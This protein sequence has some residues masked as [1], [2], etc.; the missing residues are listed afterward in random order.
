MIVRTARNIRIKL[1]LILE[2]PIARPTIQIPLSV[3]EA[4]PQKVLKQLVASV[5]QKE[6]LAD[7]LVKA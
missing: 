3:A 2:L 5:P 4:V 6:V 7:L 1:K